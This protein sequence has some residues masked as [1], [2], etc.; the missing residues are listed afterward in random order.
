MLPI[1]DR[2]KSE[3]ILPW[4]MW[5]TLATALIT[6]VFHRTA[7]A[8]VMDQL[9]RDFQIQDASVAGA[10]AGLYSMI[11]MVMQIPGGMLTDLWGSRKT[12]SYGMLVGCI[13][14]LIFAFAPNLFFA[15]LGRGLVGLGASVIFVSMLR[16]QMLWFKPSQF[17]SIS[18]LTGFAGNMGA[19][20]ATTPLAFL[21]VSVG[22]RGSFTLV[23]MVTFLIALLCWFVIRDRPHSTGETSESS[24][25]S[26]NGKWMAEA[27]TE[28]FRNKNTWYLFCT[29]IGFGG[30]LLAFTGSWSV[31]YLMQVYNLSRSQ[32]ANFAIAIILGKMIGF[33]LIG[34]VS[35]RLAKRKLP[36]LCFM[37]FHVFL[38]LL[39]YTWNAGKP[40]AVVL[41][42]IF[43]SWVYPVE[44]YS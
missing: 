8:V 14:T 11:Y 3:E 13:G 20:V 18:G 33:P 36:L 27:L 17:A 9:I 30:V 31:P 22:W 43:F 4:V 35:D 32:A 29:S 15:F 28:I 6:T 19:M 44:P 40:P 41:Y 39:L 5:G 7:L 10:L 26:N 23:S 34:F 24:S 16:I 38:W 21:V 2:I 25:N 1:R 37:A 42:A 12:V